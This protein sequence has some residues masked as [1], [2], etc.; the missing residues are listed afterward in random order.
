MIPTNLS[1]T[2]RALIVTGKETASKFALE[3]GLSQ[4]TISRLIAEDRRIDPETL[5][6]LATHDDKEGLE[7]LIAHLR[8][9]IDRSG[10][11]QS[12]VQIDAADVRLDDLTLLATEAQTNPDLRAML[13]DMAS[14]VRRYQTN[15]AAQLMAAEEQA[16]YG[17]KKPKK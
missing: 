6:T 12:E 11:L 10:R 5:R 17:A 14:L 7:I 2:L 15:E 13:H 16:P 4:S 8:D 9:E 1:S 3:R